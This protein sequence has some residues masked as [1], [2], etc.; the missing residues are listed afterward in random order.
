MTTSLERVQQLFWDAITWPT[1]VEDFVAQLDETRRGEFHSV[2]AQTQD[3]DRISRLQVYA[4]AYFY[5]LLGVMKETFVTTAALLEPAGFHNMVTDYVLKRPSTAP[6]LR[7]LGRR[8]PEFLRQSTHAQGTRLS[9]IAHVEYAISQALDCPD[10]PVL[11]EDALG[12]VPP[13]QWPALRFSSVG[14]VSVWSCQW[15]FSELFAAARQGAAV[16][17]ELLD[18]RQPPSSVLVWRQGFEVYHRSVGA[19]EARL[20]RALVTG[21]SF[22]TLCETLVAEDT[23]AEPARIAQYLQRWVRDGLIAAIG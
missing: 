22:A 1:G 17:R 14:S 6:D 2:F 7:E 19:A 10:D 16:D 5:R 18:A 23:T 12:R 15:P 11:N 13:E 4:E 20:L 8:F 9:E 21:A 3:F